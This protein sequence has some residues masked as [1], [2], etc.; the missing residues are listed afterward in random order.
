MALVFQKISEFLDTVDK[1]Y[2]SS[3]FVIYPCNPR[4]WSN[5]VTKRHPETP[6]NLTKIMLEKTLISGIDFG[7]ILTSKMTPKWPQNRPKWH[8]WAP[9]GLLGTPWGSQGAHQVPQDRLLAPIW[10]PKWHQ[11]EPNLPQHEPKWPHNDPKINQIGTLGSSGGHWG[12]PW[13]PPYASRPILA[14]ILASQWT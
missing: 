2:I 9:K 10:H 7:S 13:G 4:K 14:P 3:F 5:N 12:Q 6:Q 8:P 1:L 11:N